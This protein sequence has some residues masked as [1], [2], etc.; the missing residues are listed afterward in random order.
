MTSEIDLLRAYY[1]AH[2]KMNA[3]IHPEQFAA[4]A[5]AANAA[6]DGLI[7]LQIKR[8]QSSQTELPL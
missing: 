6:R 1:L 3:A 5:A 4:A 7:A 2:Q 8:D